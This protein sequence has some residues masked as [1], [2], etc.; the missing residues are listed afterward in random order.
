MLFTD[1]IAADEL[2]RDL[3]DVAVLMAD[4]GPDARISVVAGRLAEIRPDGPAA[5]VV[6][7]LAAAN[8][9]EPISLVAGMLQEMVE[10]G[11]LH[12]SA[13]SC[14]LA[15]AEVLAGASGVSGE[16]DVGDGPR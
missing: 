2:M 15:L 3:S 12:D 16:G 8:P 5:H 9:D 13:A 6:G 14:A 1:P 4:V 7:L 11:R 10:Q